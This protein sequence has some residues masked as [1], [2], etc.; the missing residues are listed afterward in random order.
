MLT[1][2][3]VCGG[4]NVTMLG[5]GTQLAEELIKKVKDKTLDT[6]PVIRI[7]RDENDLKKLNAEGDKIIVCTQLAWPFLK[8]DKIKLFVFL[9]ADA[10][11]FIPEYKIIENLW[12]QLRDAQYKLPEKSS[13]LIQT[14]HPEHLVFKSLYNPNTFYAAQL[15]ERRALGYPPFKYLLKLLVGNQKAALVEKEAVKMQTELSSLTKSHSGIRILGPLETSPYYHGGQYW[16]VILAKIGY[17]NYKQNT[18]L[19]LTRVPENWKIDPNPNS[20]LYFY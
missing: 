5:A 6:R 18:K 13:F 12:Q 4:V 17:E 20:L 11:I 14:G 7:D 15:D 10:S 8:W 19:L 16:Q 1:V 9:D 2:C 3:K